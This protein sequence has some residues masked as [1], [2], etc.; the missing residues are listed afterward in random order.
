MKAW[1]SASIAPY[2][3][4]LPTTQEYGWIPALAEIILLHRS[5]QC[6]G[7]M[8]IFIPLPGNRP[9]FLS[10]ITQSNSYT[11]SAVL[12]RSSEQWCICCCSGRSGGRGCGGGSTTLY[13]MS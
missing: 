3:L 10:C 1:G 5:N 11:D 12:A 8:N 9:Q 7:E 4:L 6:F 13:N 2:T